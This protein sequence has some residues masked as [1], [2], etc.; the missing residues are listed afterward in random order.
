MKTASAILLAVLATESVVTAAGADDLLDRLIQ[1]SDREVNADEDQ[2]GW[3]KDTYDRITTAPTRALNRAKEVLR[4]ND[5]DQVASQGPALPSPTPKPTPAERR[6]PT[7]E[8]ALDAGQDN[9]RTYTPEGVRVVCLAKPPLE[10]QP[11]IERYWRERPDFMPLL[12]WGS[13]EP[14]N[15][16][17][18]EEYV[19]KYAPDPGFCRTYYG[20]DIP[21]YA[22]PQ[23][24]T[25]HGWRSDQLLRQ[26]EQDRRASR[27]REQ[28]EQERIEREQDS[29]EIERKARI[30]RRLEEAEAHRRADQDAALRAYQLQH[31]H[32]PKLAPPPPEWATVPQGGLAP[33]P[34]YQS[35]SPQQPR[36]LYQ[37]SPNQPTRP[38][39]GSAMQPTVP[40]TGNNAGNPRSRNAGSIAPPKPPPPDSGTCSLYGCK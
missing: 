18:A 19:C 35:N 9:R 32:E 6:D 33:L 37:G 29:A 13:K 27:E 34:P 8:P 38:S 16:E 4:G 26:A 22:K 25:E 10:R 23:W 5:D 40:W 2:N 36:A 7:R 21:E 1:G 3:M 39:T 15:A 17:A 20:Y 31:Q 12:Q 24:T 11:C 28:Q 30:Q 14:P